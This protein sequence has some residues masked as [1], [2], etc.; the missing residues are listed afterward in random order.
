MWVNF[1][2]WT[3]L[4]VNFW[5][6]GQFLTCRSIL[7]FDGQF[8]TWRS[9]LDPIVDFL[10]SRSVFGVFPPKTIFSASESVF[11]FQGRFL[12]WRSI[13]GHDQDF[14]RQKWP[15]TK[16]RPRPTQVHP[17]GVF[18]PKSTKIGQPSKNAPKSTPVHHF[19]SNQ[20]NG[21]E[22]PILACLLYILSLFPPK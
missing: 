14:S 20:E 18:P 1:W 17:Q 21:P 13:F 10:T 5:L 8:W 4:T 19:R 15:K 22:Q 9:I 12:T 7:T 6:D 3:V 2:F 16:I 11:D